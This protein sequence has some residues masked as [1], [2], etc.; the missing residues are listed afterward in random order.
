MNNKIRIRFAPS[1]TGFLHVGSLR[2]VLFDY[3]IAKSLNGKLILRIE[4]TDQKREVAGAVDGLI[5]ILKWVGLEFDEGPHVGGDHGPYVQTERL[6]IYQKYLQE[7]LDKDGAYHCFCSP[8][9]LEIM[10]QEQS[11]NKMPPRYDRSCR[12]LTSDEVK[13][14]INNG[15]QFVIRQKMPLSGEIIVNDELKGEIKFKLSDLDDQILIKSNGIPTY[16]F[17]NVVDDH[18]M[19]I[20]HVLRG[21]EWISS[22]PK[23]IILY[24]LFDWNPPKFIHMSL[25]LNKDGGKLS[26]RQGDVAVEDY[27]GKGYL[28]D[29]LLNFSVLQGWSPNASAKMPPDKTDEILSLDEMI[30][31]FDYHDMGTSPAI[32]EIDKL[33]YF[34]GY[35]IRQKNIE[36]MTEMS[37]PYLVKD[38]IIIVRDKKYYNNFNNLEISLN[39]ISK[40]IKTAQERLKKISDVSEYTKF[41]FIEEL[42]Y[43]SELLIWKT[44]TIDQ[45]KE[46]LNSIYIFLDNLDESM[47]INENIEKE[48]L[49]FIQSITGKNGDYLW[50]MRVSLTGLKNSPS[51]FEVADVLGKKESLKRINLAIKKIS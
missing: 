5:D 4:D 32:F 6:E 40:A 27:R 2:T 30:A 7:L 48:V 42:D 34:N 36:S 29:A 13:K 20:S 14:K 38:G 21:D 45:T 51:P 11:A 25:S 33:D 37:I 50:P 3:L 23:N 47:W 12:D 15:E 19:E 18:T 41:Y 44:N 26:K 35:Y 22:L 43:S 16:Q 9:R 1:P 39:F 46:N 8:E 28:P 24:K 10:R 31:L 17:A 49:Q